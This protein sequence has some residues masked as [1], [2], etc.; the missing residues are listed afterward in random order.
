MEKRTVKMGDYDTAANG[1]TLAAWEFP[2]PEVVTNLVEVPGRAQGPL[3]L[4]TA[5]TGETRY[6]SRSLSVTL[7][8]SEGDRLARDAQISALVNQ[9]H[10][11]RVDIVLPDKTTHYAVGRLAIETLYSDMAHASVQ[12]SGVC[13]PWLYAA[14]ETEVSGGVSAD[15]ETT[16]TTVEL[17]NS[18]LLTVVPVIEVSKLKLGDA[19]TVSIILTYSPPG[20]ALV[21]YSVTLSE[22][23]YR[24]PALRLTPGTHT[25]TVTHSSGGMA[26][27]AFT[28]REAVL[29]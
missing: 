15:A 21:G 26:K 11:Q 13:E 9:L 28:Y 27:V 1:W 3:D 10:G 8:T 14:E 2:E 6:G 17:V 24:W 12:V 5:L 20:A 4:S 22:G 18:G 19:E 23:E 25:V 16:S 7:E 29:R